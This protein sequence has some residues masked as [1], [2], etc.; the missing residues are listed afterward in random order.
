MARTINEE[1]KLAAAEALAGIITDDE[2]APD[3]IIPK[4]FDT[5]VRP[6]IAEAVANAA[7]KTGVARR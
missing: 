4:A 3:H 1:M 2:L 7:R 6:A 5:R